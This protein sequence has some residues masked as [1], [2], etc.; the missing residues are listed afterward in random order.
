MEKSRNSRKTRSMRWVGLFCLVAPWS[1]PALAQFSADSEGQTTK[2]QPPPKARMV[3]PEAPEDRVGGGLDATGRGRSLDENETQP[4]AG[5]GT[6]GDTATRAP[7]GNARSAP[8][9]SYAGP[10]LSGSSGTWSSSGADRG[11]EWMGSSPENRNGQS[12]GASAVGLNSRSDRSFGARGGLLNSSGDAG[13][14]TNDGGIGNSSKGGPNSG[15][16]GME[17]SLNSFGSSNG[18][19]SENANGNGNKRSNGGPTENGN[20]GG[21]RSTAGAGVV[22]MPRGGNSSGERTASSSGARNSN[23]TSANN[24]GHATRNSEKD[25]SDADGEDRSARNDSNAN[26]NDAS[27]GDNSDAPRGGNSDGAAKQSAPDRPEEEGWSGSTN[28]VAQAAARRRIGDLT[29][30]TAGRDLL[31]EKRDAEAVDADDAL[32]GIAGRIDPLTGNAEVK[33]PAAGGVSPLLRQVVETAKKRK[34]K[35]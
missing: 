18:A 22:N 5:F 1:F 16:A 4:G 9:S 23:D 30:G 21:G 14:N 24:S 35:K 13:G 28:P 19:R 10:A 3:R 17:G 27:N 34:Q 11:Y 15:S 26:E 20:A 31:G 7:R 8:G 32:R 6:R 2:I 29:V 33:A 12:D 25:N